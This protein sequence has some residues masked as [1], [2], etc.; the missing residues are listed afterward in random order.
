MDFDVIVVGSGQAAVPLATRLAARGRK[1]LL[2]ERA[3]LGGTCVNTG[4]TPTKTLIASARAAHV[5][6]TAERLG[7]HAG[8]VRVD[9]PAVVARKDAMVERWRSGVA[10]VGADAAR[11]L[12]AAVTTP[13]DRSPRRSPAPAS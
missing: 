6:R 2:A 9:F 1:V 4:C 3:H 8:P 11:P 5:A 7:V 12:P 10:P 13:P